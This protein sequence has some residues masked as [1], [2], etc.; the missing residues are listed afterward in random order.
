MIHTKILDEFYQF[1][2]IEIKVIMGSK[3]IES[4][5]GGDGISG[6]HARI[7]LLTSTLQQ[8][9]QEMRNDGGPK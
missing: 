9:S 4:A 2:S 7:I 5:G 3:S 8:S 1:I 6:S